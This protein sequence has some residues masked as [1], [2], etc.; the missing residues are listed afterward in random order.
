MNKQAIINI[1]REYSIEVDNFNNAVF[2][3]DFEDVA[4][5]LMNIFDKNLHK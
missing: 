2:S 3:Q 5:K 4:E 1:L